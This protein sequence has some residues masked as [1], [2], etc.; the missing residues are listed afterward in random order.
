MTEVRVEGISKH[1]D[2]AL[3]AGTQT[4]PNR[5]GEPMR[6]GRT[7]VNRPRGIPAAQLSVVRTLLSAAAFAACA[8]FAQDKAMIPNDGKAQDTR[9]QTY[10][11]LQGEW[12][13]LCRA[14]VKAMNEWLTSRPDQPACANRVL[15]TLPYVTRDNWT[16]LDLVKDKPLFLRYALA[17]TTPKAE[18]SRVFSSSPPK[19]GS[20][21]SSGVMPSAVELE[22]VWGRA[23]VDGT[24]FYKVH[25]PKPR[26]SPDDVLLVVFWNGSPQSRI[27][28]TGS[29]IL[30]S[31]SLEAPVLNWRR[32]SG[33][34]VPFDYAKI[35]YELWES[36]SGS[37]GDSTQ[38]FFLSRVDEV[39]ARRDSRS[40]WTESVPRPICQAVLRRATNEA[41]S[42]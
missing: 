27:C 5:T 29:S 17:S 33:P 14:M 18:W 2:G 32:V 41:G 34:D 42:K 8:T 19:P 10:K 21:L 4:S 11:L 9:A 39:E 37:V 16:R 12:T 13:P 40:Q 23:L 20:K 36:P 38:E 6:E 7:T 3:L 30:F 26:I 1:A 24:E 15:T 22:A 31:A 35:P 25:S 28:P